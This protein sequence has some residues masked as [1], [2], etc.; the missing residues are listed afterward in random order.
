[1]LLGVCN[2]SIRQTEALSVVG[3]VRKIHVPATVTTS[4]WSLKKIR[5]R[6]L[7]F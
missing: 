2:V 7:A 3:A 5:K 1:M 6:L 4:W